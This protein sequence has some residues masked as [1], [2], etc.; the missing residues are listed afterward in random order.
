MAIRFKT[1]AAFYVIVCAFTTGTAAFS[2][3]ADDIKICQE[4]FAKA[5]GRNLEQDSAVWEPYIF[6]PNEV[7]FPENRVFCK[8]N[9]EGVDH[10]SEKNHVLIRE[11]WPIGNEKLYK[12]LAEKIDG[13][14]A[15]LED[16]IDQY[17]NLM[18]A[19]E[20]SL[21][22]PG[23]EP[24]E[25]LAELEG[26]IATIF[27]KLLS[28]DKNFE[29]VEI[30]NLR[31]NVAECQARREF[32]ESELTTCRDQIKE[33]EQSNQNVVEFQEN[34]RDLKGY[35]K[36]KQFE[37]ARTMLIN[38]IRTET[39]LDY[40]VA[41]L[42]NATL[43]L[44]KPLSASKVRLNRDGYR[45]LTALDPE[46][47]EYRK[48]YTQYD[49]VLLN[50]EPATRVSSD[51]MIDESEQVC[52]ALV[53]FVL[54]ATTTEDVQI[55]DV[56]K[57]SNPYALEKT[58]LAEYRSPFDERTYRVLCGIGSTIATHSSLWDPELGREQYK[59]VKNKN[60][61]YRISNGKVTFTWT[62]VDGSQSTDTISL[63]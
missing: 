40:N 28:T 30:G 20:T 38:E 61:S 4:V 13:K 29:N 60:I 12:R 5:T 11:G 33:T 37:K 10:L 58:F 39:L 42:E 2:G 21:M 55:L 3:E 26:N 25:R 51:V 16:Q 56:S 14:I 46:N 19:G 52:K 63:K 45:L 48:K 36:S 23:G 49:E 62:H 17:Q 8:V 34:M 9:F 32:V 50:K 27:S 59:W 7:E 47:S 44:V 35:I 31:S 6:S 1:C 41:E 24:Q 43:S 54:S 18:Q 53:V 15:L 22:K 57:F